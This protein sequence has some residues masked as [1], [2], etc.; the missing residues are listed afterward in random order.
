MADHLSVS[1]RDALALRLV[2]RRTW[3]FFEE[4][5]TADDNM[6]PPDNFQEDHEPV[7]AHRT[8]P[9]NL[10]LHLLS[11]VA[12]HDFGWLGTLGTLDRLEATFATMAKLARFRGNLAGHLITLR[13]AC[14]EITAGA[15]GSQNWITGLA[16][17]IALLREAEGLQTKDE[18]RPSGVRAKL[19]DAIGAFTLRL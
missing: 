14:L 10:S 17:T 13:N 2:A 9:T 7:I 8:S 15:I 5:I 16:D 3:R 18:T 12:A 6:L 19:N 4:F 11:I 1:A